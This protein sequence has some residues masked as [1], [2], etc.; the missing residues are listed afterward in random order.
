MIFS[1]LKKI[2]VKE[3]FSEIRRKEPSR[4]KDIALKYGVDV[5]PYEIGVMDPGSKKEKKKDDY[6]HFSHIN[7]AFLLLFQELQN[8]QNISKKA[9]Q[10]KQL[11]FALKVLDMYLAQHDLKEEL[12]KEYYNVEWENVNRLVKYTENKISDYIADIFPNKYQKI[13]KLIDFIGQVATTRIASITTGFDLYGQAKHLDI[14]QGINFL[15]G[16]Q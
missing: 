1:E 2:V 6:P 10:D 8:L 14:P 3:L 4:Y 9:E 7:Q 15:G 11:N 5:T 16:A 12:L 13:M